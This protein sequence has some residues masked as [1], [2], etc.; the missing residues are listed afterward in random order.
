MFFLKRI[1]D[2]LLG[3][4]VYPLW[5]TEFYGENEWAIVKQALEQA[6]NYKTVAYL[7][8][9]D[10]LRTQ[11]QKPDLILKPNSIEQAVSMSREMLK[12]KIVDLLVID[13]LFLLP[14][15]KPRL[16]ESLSELVKAAEK[17]AKPIFLLNPDNGARRLL[18]K[19]LKSF[20]S[21]QIWV[22]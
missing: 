13:S 1:A 21:S 12:T 17:N 18:E 9:F 7:D 8:P 10:N 20:C 11:S 6:W 5:L 19:N 15:D 3:E 22:R 14:S 4:D 16:E 2:C